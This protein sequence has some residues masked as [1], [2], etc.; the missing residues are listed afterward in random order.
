[1][2]EAKLELEEIVD[3]LRQPAKYQKLGGRIPRGV[4]LVGA[5]R[6]GKDAA[7]ES[8]RGRSRCCVLFYFR[9]GIRRDVCRRGRGP[10]S[11]PV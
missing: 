11:R 6:D 10:R 9:F 3:F 4:L 5:S 7:G 1:M 8:R 2:D